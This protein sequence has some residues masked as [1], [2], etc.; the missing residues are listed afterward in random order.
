MGIGLSGILCFS[1]RM[2][3]LKLGMAFCIA[4]SSIAL[5]LYLRKKIQ[6]TSVKGGT[7]I[8]NTLD[9]KNKVTSLRSIKKIRTKSA[10][11]LQWTSLSYNLDGRDQNAIIVN[12][13]SAVPVLPETAIKK[14][15]ALNKK[16]KANHKPGPVH[17]S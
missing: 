8:L 9:N 14:A 1:G 17:E 6:S 11:G 2:T 3:F 12:K 5:F 10:L 4:A 7:L 13:A 16:E 15:I